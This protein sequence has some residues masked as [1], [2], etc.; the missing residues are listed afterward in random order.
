MCEYF[1][2]YLNEIMAEVM[3]EIYK[4][5]EIKLVKCSECKND[6][7]IEETR[8]DKCTDCRKR[9]KIK[10]GDVIR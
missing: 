6:V 2:E 1:N 7:N 5:D 3:E 4:Q 9:D 10:T 8:D